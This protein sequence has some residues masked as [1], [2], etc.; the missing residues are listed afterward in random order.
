MG[1]QLIFEAKLQRIRQ[2]IL[3]YRDQGVQLM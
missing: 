2:N 3:S 1:Q